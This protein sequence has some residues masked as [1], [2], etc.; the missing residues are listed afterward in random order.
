LWG[1]GRGVWGSGFRVQVHQVLVGM[2]AQG[3]F[4]V[5]LLDGIGRGALLQAWG[6]GE[7]VRR[8]GV[9]V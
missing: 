9:R 1:V 5:G 4:A 2:P 8:R 3:Q 6:C 7:G